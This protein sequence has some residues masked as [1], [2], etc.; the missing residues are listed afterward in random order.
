M[1]DKAGYVGVC[2]GDGGTVS[3]TVAGT[4]GAA[5]LDEHYPHWDTPLTCDEFSVYNGFKKRQ[6]CWA[7]MLRESEYRTHS[8][9]PLM[10]LL[11][12]RLQTIFHDAKFIPPDKG[13]DTGPMALEV[14]SIAQAYLQHG[15]RVFGTKLHNAADHLFTFV[16]HPGMDPTNNETER[17]VRRIV[18]HRKIRMR[19]V[20]PGGMR[21]FGILMTCFLTW[22]R[23]GLD[24]H[25]KILEV[26]ACT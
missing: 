26:L 4:R 10:V 22:R 15:Q 17:M 8:N 11:H 5:V 23:R 12:H 13:I 18:L 3:V 2:L 6:R 1:G 7:H 19:M 20:N 9:D 21:M 16:N 14:K 24:I 25:Q